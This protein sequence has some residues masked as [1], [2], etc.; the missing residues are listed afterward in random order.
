MSGTEID[1][2]LMVKIIALEKDEFLVREGKNILDQLPSAI[3]IMQMYDRQIE[4]WRN[5]GKGP[6]PEIPD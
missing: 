3:Y 5:G 1:P 4:F 2:E 6:Y